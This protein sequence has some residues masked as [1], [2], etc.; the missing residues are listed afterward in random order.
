M[1][2]GLDATVP[3]KG[4]EPAPASHWI[5]KC[6]L[7]IVGILFAISLLELPALLKLVDYRETRW[8]SY[9][10]F[11]PELIFIHRPHSSHFG[12]YRG[13]NFAALYNEPMA[14]RS[15][16]ETNVIYDRNGFRNP[17][18]LTKADIVFVGSYSLEGA[19]IPADQLMTAVL[20]QDRH[21]VVAN[22]GQNAYS[23]Q[24][25][26]IVLR[27]F[28]LPLKPQT[29]VWIYT[30]FN[31]MRQVH[32]FENQTHHK[33]GLHAIL[34]SSF[35]KNAVLNLIHTFDEAEVDLKNAFFPNPTR[36]PANLSGVIPNT[37]QGP[38]KVYFLYPSWPLGEEE[39]SSISASLKI[40][41]RANEL[42]AAQG[43]R[44]VVVFVP[45]EFRVLNG[46]IESPPQSQIRKWVVTDIPDRMKNG[47]EAISPQIG[48]LD[49]TP[50]MVDAVRRGEMPYFTDDSHFSPVGHR[51]AAE[52]IDEY[53]TQTESSK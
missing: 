20:A 45:Q 8:L 24:Q 44:L 10:R 47:I 26:L 43:A 25:D 50:V 39:F 46:F 52:A 17:T 32:S 13:G 7:G 4:S 22:L 5:R 36:N 12:T 21:A 14:D 2:N 11:D 48:F 31:D 28:G 38:Q 35:T 49:L 3:S 37:K 40:L 19:T 41:T 51:I 9:N 33:S 27:R 53:L 16:Y 29:V 1:N 30:E 6:L 18:D 34:Q 42:C 23:P 15:T